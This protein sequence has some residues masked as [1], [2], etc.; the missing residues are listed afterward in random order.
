M[1]LRLPQLEENSQLSNKQRPGRKN[2][3]TEKV[4]KTGGK[5]LKAIRSLTIVT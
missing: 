4:A 3:A 1:I 2:E 5:F